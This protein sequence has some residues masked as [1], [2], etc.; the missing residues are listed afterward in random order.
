MYYS[1]GENRRK[2]WYHLLS[3]GHT[4]LLVLAGLLVF[5][6]ITVLTVLL[7]YTVRAMKYD[8][9]RVVT[10]GSVSTLYDCDNKPVVPLSGEDVLP[11]RWE[12]LP[13]NLVNAFVAREDELL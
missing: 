12:E 4:K 3:I 1:Q 2:R 9:E 7:T 13:R 10:G 8:L 6:I 5:S 11:V